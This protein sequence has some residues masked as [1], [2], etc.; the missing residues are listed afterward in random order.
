MKRPLTLLIIA[1]SVL[2]CVSS[3]WALW[4]HNSLQGT[5]KSIASN[6]ITIDSI[7]NPG[8]AA[9]KTD[10]AI[11]MQE[12]S[13]QV[14]DKTKLNELSSVNDLKE[15]D[16]VKISYKEDSGQKVATSVERVKDKKASL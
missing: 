1:A 15:G 16:T 9:N 3:G 11:E 12:V 10:A 13:F 6:M 4:E 7:S 2:W 5:V 14:N 8:R